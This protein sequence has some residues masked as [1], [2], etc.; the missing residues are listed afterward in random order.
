MND[1]ISINYWEDKK[2]QSWMDKNT[3][4]VGR[5]AFIRKAVANQIKYENSKKLPKQSI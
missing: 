1:R 5:S 4:K 2:S 3:G